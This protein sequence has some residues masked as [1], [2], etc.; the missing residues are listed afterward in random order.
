MFNYAEFPLLDFPEKLLQT[1]FLVPSQCGRCTNSTFICKL[2]LFVTA[3]KWVF[4]CSTNVPQ[5]WT[6]I[7]PWHGFPTESGVWYRLPKICFRN[8]RGWLA[9]G[10]EGE[11]RRNRVQTKLVATKT[12]KLLLYDWQ[13]LMFH[14]CWLR[15]GHGCWH[16]EYWMQ[17]STDIETALPTFVWLS[18]KNK[19]R[20]TE[21]LNENYAYFW[22]AFY[23]MPR[24]T[25]PEK[26]QA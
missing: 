13:Q 11:T 15:L 14:A 8:R 4:L 23:V 26:I 6:W 19:R 18:R 5:Q 10:K 12:T 9:E 7:R 17:V 22:C 2:S 16:S 1:F 25:P 20:Q 21:K 24:K 3:S